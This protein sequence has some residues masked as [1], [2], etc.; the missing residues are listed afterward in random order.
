MLTP[1]PPSGRRV[2]TLKSLRWFVPGPV[3]LVLILGWGPQTPG[4][5][6]VKDREAV[7]H[8]GERMYRPFRGQARSYRICV[9]PKHQQRFRFIVG[10]NLFAKADFQ[11]QK[12]WRIYGPFRGQVS[13]HGFCVQSQWRSA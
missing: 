8:L 2:P 7:F 6:G 3:L 1:E 4:S 13:S 12:M 5:S 11:A 9:R 10:A